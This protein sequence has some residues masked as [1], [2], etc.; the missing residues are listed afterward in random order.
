MLSTVTDIKTIMKSNPDG[1]LTIA[2]SPNGL[3]GA[4]ALAGLPTDEG[5]DNDGYGV[6]SIVSQVRS[7]AISHKFTLTITGCATEK[8]VLIGLGLLVRHPDVSM[9][10]LTEWVN[11]GIREFTSEFTDEFT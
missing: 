3:T 9:Q 2:Y 7:T 11:S 8:P 10:D 6:R 1:V 4:V 5:I